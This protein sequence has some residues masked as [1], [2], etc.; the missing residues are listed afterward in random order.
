MLA[1]KYGVAR[2]TLGVRAKNENWVSLRKQYV[3]DL[4]TKME[5]AAKDEAVTKG[6]E[7]IRE[8]GDVACGSVRRLQELID[9]APN[10]TQAE[11]SVSALR[12]LLLI[13]RDCY[14]L[15]TAQELEKAKLDRDKLELEREKVSRNAPDESED[16]IIIGSEVYGL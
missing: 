5:E 6:L 15:L 1:K 10:G 14:G 11:A 9:A 3:D 12:S 7:A 4:S 13:I 2:H 16:R 8:I